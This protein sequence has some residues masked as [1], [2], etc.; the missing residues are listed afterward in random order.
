MA[1]SIGEVKKTHLA[2]E[3]EFDYNEARL[4]HFYFYYIGH[5]NGFAIGKRDWVPI[6]ILNGLVSGPQ[7]LNQQLSDGT[8][9]DRGSPLWVDWVNANHDVVMR[10]VAPSWERF[11]RNIHDELRLSEENYYADAAWFKHNGF[12]VDEEQQ[13]VKVPGYQPL[14]FV[15]NQDL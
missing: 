1:T 9:I 6:S 8:L 3:A 5:V 7:L 14:F 13:L 2:Q 15:G 11:S 12:E 4:G 10:S